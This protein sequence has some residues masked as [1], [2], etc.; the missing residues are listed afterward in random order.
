MKKDNKKAAISL[1]VGHLTIDSYTGFINPIMPFIVAKL[2]ISLVIATTI[3]SISHLCSSIIQPVFG[4]MADILQKRFFIFWGLIIAAFFLSMLGH[5]NSAV[6]LAVFLALGSVGVAFFHP[7]ATSFIKQHAPVE[8]TKYMSIFLALGTAGFSLGPLISSNIVNFAGL[9]NLSF[10]MIYGF[11]VAFLILKFVPKVSNES[12]FVNFKKT[13]LEKD[14]FNN[15]FTA[16][17]E[18]FTN[19]EFNI[20]FAI[21][22][23][24]C[25]TVSSFCVYLPFLWE[26][27]GYSV[28]E[29]GFYIFLF[30]SAGALA[31]LS[32]SIFEKI[33]ST[34]M[35]YYFSMLTILPLT[36]LFVFTYQKI[37]WLSLIAF[38][39]IGFFAL[40]A[41]PVNM[42]M[43]QNAVP[44]HKGL[45]SGFIGGFSWGIV[46]L[47]LPITGFFAEHFGIPTLLVVIAIIPLIISFFVRFLKK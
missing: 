1:G 21:A 19:K 44:Q 26:K 29:I 28:S 37:A 9:K 41:I 3:I 43:A 39:L 4:Y 31:T 11:V 6:T 5:A 23:A 12:S 16:I 14:F 27:S 36:L 38:V 40:I 10:A 32:S 2:G 34:H 18:S 22:V 8:T 45:I 30:V 24:K 7:Q 47:I 20:L 35:I 15:F 13:V 33:F 17:K 46:G 25:L 42:V